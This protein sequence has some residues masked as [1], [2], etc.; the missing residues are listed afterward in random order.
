MDELRPL[1][2]RQFLVLGLLLLF[3]AAIFFQLLR[4]NLAEGE[5]LRRLWSSQTIHY[6]P[7][8]AERGGIYA[9]NG[10]RLAGNTT[11]YTIAVDPHAPGA[12]S[13]GFAELSRILAAHTGR[14]SSHYMDR[15]RSASRGSRYII[16]ERNLGADA[17]DEIRKLDAKGI[18]VEEEYRRTYG[19]ASLASHVLG[20]VNRNLEG[21]SGLELHYNH[22]LKGEDGLQQ[23]R[24]DRS[25][26][27]YSYV[28]APRKTPVHG[29]SIHTTIDPYIQAIV[30][31][32][33]RKGVTETRSGYGTA[34]VMDPR[35]GAIRAM[36]NFPDFDPNQPAT[37][38]SENRRNFAVSDMIE[39][40]STFKLVTAIAAVEQ[41]V[42]DFDEL[43]ETPADGRKVIHG[44]VMRD[45]DPLGTVNF[46]Q[47]IALSSNIAI[48]E[49]AMRLPREIF[50]QY[51]RN[52]GF[53]TLTSI[54]LP[55]EEPGVL[56]R[57]H[58]WSGVSL[59]WMSIGYEVQVTPL[60]L[61]QAYA[62]FAN[63]GKLMRPYIVDRITNEYGETVRMN[64]PV[65]IR[66]VASEETIRKL[67]PVF[68]QVVSDSGTASWAQVDGLDIAGKTGT[69][70]KFIDNR[71]RNSYRA[72]FV[73]F[74]PVEEPKY[75]ILVILDEPRTSFYGGRTAGVI[76]REIAKRITGLDSDLQRFIDPSDR[77]E[78]Q[79]SACPCIPSLAGLEKEAAMKL[80]SELGIDYRT[81][82]EGPLVV[83]QS[84]EPGSPAGRD[85]L[86]LTLGFSEH[87]AAERSNQESATEGAAAGT[88]RIRVPDLTGMSMRQA[89]TLLQSLGLDLEMI[90]SG[91][92]HTQFPK[93][94]E[95]MR[96]GRKVTVRGRI[97]EFGTSTMFSLATE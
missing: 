40:G 75:T 87:S 33:L 41:G 31:E 28:G 17:H 68:R 86:R 44:Q 37:S 1:Q 94:G 4:I 88:E 63:K 96:P 67:L 78:R 10:T 7:I 20:F 15:I 64:R 22:L 95:W 39:P 36:A 97:R 6:I 65:E 11:G 2:N 52:L 25:N 85:P 69:V 29:Y 30:E 48:S 34:I 93:S 54:D 58:E 5:E 81:T 92:I 51:A 26:R 77:P 56:R 59:P 19:F 53:G 43:F 3:P 90:G 23:V 73:G 61:V 72:S 45:H 74:F 84:G 71:Y 8:S 83:S 38:D 42:V 57:P 49:I 60:Q 27:I 70:Q 14:P 32:E 82:G 46:A 16:L 76:F 21:V 13:G 55:N 66:R 79:E 24:R 35:T 12:T 9:S 62:A 91:T 47:A 18:I 50:Y 80:L 89:A